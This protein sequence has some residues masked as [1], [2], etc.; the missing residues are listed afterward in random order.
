MAVLPGGCDPLS[1]CP[2]CVPHTCWAGTPA[3]PAASG[4]GSSVAGQCTLCVGG[5]AIDESYAFGQRRS[6]TFGDSVVD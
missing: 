3:I 6:F 2:T 4:T 5:S 1:N